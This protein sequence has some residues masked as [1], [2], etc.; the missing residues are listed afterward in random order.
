MS[1]FMRIIIVLFDNLTIYKRFVL[2]HVYVCVRISK[3]PIALTHFGVQYIP[4]FG[5]ATLWYVFFVSIVLFDNLAIRR[6]TTIKSMFMR[7]S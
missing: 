5:I 6:F 7:I 4:P 2:L 3:V 1:M